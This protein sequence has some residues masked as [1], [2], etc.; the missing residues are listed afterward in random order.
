M[1]VKY[2]SDSVESMNNKIGLISIVFVQEIHKDSKTT[3]AGQKN[4]IEM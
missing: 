3:A 4:G 1:Q 2:A